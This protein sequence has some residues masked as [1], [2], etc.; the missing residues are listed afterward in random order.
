MTEKINQAI[1]RLHKFLG[2]VEELYDAD[3][4]VMAANAVL[5]VYFV[6]MAKRDLI[7]P[8]LTFTVR[9]LYVVKNSQGDS[10]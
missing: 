7:K 3:L 4:L 10:A 5:P 8:E 2:V 1:E 9:H 6:L